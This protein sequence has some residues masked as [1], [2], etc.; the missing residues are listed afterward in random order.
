MK[1]TPRSMSIFCAYAATA[2][3]A[4]GYF[5][6]VSAMSERVLCSRGERVQRGDEAALEGSR[7]SVESLGTAARR[8]DVRDIGQGTGPAS[9]QSSRVDSKAS[10]R[11]RPRGPRV[12]RTGVTQLIPHNDARDVWIP[13]MQL[14]IVSGPTAGAGPARAVFFSELHSRGRR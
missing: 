6:R 4:R 8:D 5:V 13:R 12:S 11:A 14:M 9:E 7:H 10:L 3:T 1:M 2:R